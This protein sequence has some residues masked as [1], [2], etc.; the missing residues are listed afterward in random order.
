MFT[1]DEYEW[2]LIEAEQGRAAWPTVT[3]SEW[4]HGYCNFL[5]CE[6]PGVIRDGDFW[7][8][9]EHAEEVYG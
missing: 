8:C 6:L 9:E 5:F 1:M 4:D 7:I 3:R 2:N